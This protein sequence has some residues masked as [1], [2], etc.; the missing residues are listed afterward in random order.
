MNLSKSNSQSFEIENQ[1]HKP[2]IKEI[3]MIQQTAA[4][5]MNLIMS[6]FN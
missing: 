3:S 2:T 4:F 6:K 5:Q 1:P